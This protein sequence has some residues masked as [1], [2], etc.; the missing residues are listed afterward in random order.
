MGY[1]RPN[2]ALLNSIKEDRI[3]KAGKGWATVVPKGQLAFLASLFE[4]VP[5]SVYI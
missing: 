4:E 5:A 2:W 3:H 1:G